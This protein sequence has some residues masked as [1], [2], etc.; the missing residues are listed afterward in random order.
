[1]ATRRAQAEAEIEKLRAAMASPN[2]ATKRATTAA[3][4]AETTAW[5]AA[6]AMAQEKAALESKVTDLEQDLATT[7]A[8]LTTANHQ[9]SKVSTQLQVA[10]KEATWLREDNSK[11]SQDLDGESDKP[12]FSPLLRLACFLFIL[13]CLL[14]LQGCACTTLG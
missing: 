2:E 9:F 5:D 10:A 3:A 1:L 6:Q 4:T 8:D 14:V 11:L 13:T 12:F 7:K